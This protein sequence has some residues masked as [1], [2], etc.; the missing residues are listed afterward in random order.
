MKTRLLPLTLITICLCLSQVFAGD[1][2]LHKKSQPYDPF[3]IRDSKQAD[4][5]WQQQQQLKK[6]IQLIQSLP[7]GCVLVVRPFDHYRCGG[8]FYRPLPVVDKNGDG[9]L[10]QQYQLIPA[11]TDK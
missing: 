6:Q 11:P 2:T 10:Q 8:L 4:H 3:V 5:Q 1:I 7:L 9:Q